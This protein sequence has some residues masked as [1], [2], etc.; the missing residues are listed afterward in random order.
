MRTLIRCST[1][2]SDERDVPR[3]WPTE[4]MYPVAIPSEPSPCA[5]SLPEAI[6]KSI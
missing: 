5:P 6:C 3:S 2:L 4:S 1:V